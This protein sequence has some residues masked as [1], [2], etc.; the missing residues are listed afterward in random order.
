MP[1]TVFITGASRGIGR[2]AAFAFARAGWRVGVGFHESEREAREVI[3]ALGGMGGMAAAARG[4][5]ADFADV[6]RM[7]REVEASLGPITALVNNAGVALDAELA[8]TSCEQWRRVFAVNAEG[9]YNAC[10]CVLPGMIERGEGAI[11]NVSSVW[12]VYGGACEAAYSASKAALIGLTRALAREAGPGGVRVNCV[13]PGVID[14]DMNARLTQA[15]R[16][17]LRDRTPLCRL[18]T[19]AEVAEAILFLASPAASFVT[20][21]VLGVDGG[22]VG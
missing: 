16:A 15:E 9:A 12:G 19:A 22:F 11:V 10:R 14:T 18:G 21:Q 17:S 2:A 6:A 5:V 8:D 20:G 3:A 13:A 7:T 1:G 4:D